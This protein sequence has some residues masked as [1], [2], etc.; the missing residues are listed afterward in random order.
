M[1]SLT[2]CTM[3][4]NVHSL[5]CS[6]FSSLSHCTLGVT[7]VFCCEAAAGAPF[8]RVSE[9]RF[10]QLAFEDALLGHWLDLGESLHKDT[11]RM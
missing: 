2:L 4:K 6:V 3:D 11:N 5:S 1:Y 10:R 8:A 9:G 7:A